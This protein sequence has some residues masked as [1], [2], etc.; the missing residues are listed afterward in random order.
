VETL[1]EAGEPGTVLEAL[2]D[3]ARRD[4]HPAVQRRR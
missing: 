1:G 2:A 4:P 3:I